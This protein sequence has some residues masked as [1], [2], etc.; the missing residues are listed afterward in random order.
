METG[1]RSSEVC[2]DPLVR[3]V[4][5][6]LDRKGDRIY[7]QLR[8]SG[9]SLDWSRTFFTMDEVGL[10]LI[11]S[12][13]L[14]PS[15][16]SL[17]LSLCHLS[18]SYLSVTSLRHLSLFLLPLSVLSLFLLPLSVTSLSFLPLSVTSLSSSY[19]SLLH[20]SPSYLSLLHLSPSSLSLSLFSSEALSCSE[21]MFC[22]F[23]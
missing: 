21:R 12:L 13:Y 19:L 2:G 3:V 16:L 5:V 10:T 22:T 23:T 1:V 15:Y 4:H 18:P 7:H 17:S 9:C 14:F 11:P 6:S 20:P 8:K